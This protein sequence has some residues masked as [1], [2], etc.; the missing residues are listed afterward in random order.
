MY[1]VSNIKYLVEKALLVIVLAI[2]PFVLSACLPQL[3]GG[4]APKTEEFASGK[5]VKG[6]P[7]SIPLYKGSLIIESYGGTSGYGAS[8]MSDD[9]LAKVVNF[10]NQALPQLGWTVN[11]KQA[12][13]TNYVYEIKN[14]TNSGQV[15]VN[16]AADGK[17][18]AIT[19]SVGER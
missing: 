7:D 10:Y 15:I 5:V 19:M 4:S 6:F 14:E 17:K 9:N 8:F 11:P 1:Q 3:G 12:S 2:M 16:T 18:T 13:Q